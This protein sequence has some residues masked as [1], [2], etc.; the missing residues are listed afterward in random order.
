MIMTFRD[1]QKHRKEKAVMVYSMAQLRTGNLVNTKQALNIDLTKIITSLG[2]MGELEMRA[3]RGK[4][5]Q[6][7]CLP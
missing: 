2:K 1:K 4:R 6:N 5:K 3:R 7:P